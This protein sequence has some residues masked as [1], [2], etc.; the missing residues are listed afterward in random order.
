MTNNHKVITAATIITIAIAI[1]IAVA[2]ATTEV[3][4]KELA[5]QQQ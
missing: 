3:I 1:L 4:A 2:M 5:I